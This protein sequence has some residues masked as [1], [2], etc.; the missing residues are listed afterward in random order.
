VIDHRSPPHL[1]EFPDGAIEKSAAGCG[2]HR[3]AARHM[4]SAVRSFG[5][6]RPFVDLVG[7]HRDSGKNAQWSC[8]E[9][10]RSERIVAGEHFRGCLKYF[11]L[12]P[13]PARRAPIAGFLRIRI[14]QL[15]A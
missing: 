9:P 1:I 5:F 14:G 3:M 8:R 4:V 7:A 11:G 6:R 12:V 2:V 15:L 10:L 13:V